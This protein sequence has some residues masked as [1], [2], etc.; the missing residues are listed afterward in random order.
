MQ[1]SISNMPHESTAAPT[2]LATRPLA[3]CLLAIWLSVS[4]CDAIFGSKSDETTDEIF[5]EGQIDPTL[6]DNVG[7]VPLNPFYTLSMLGGFDAPIDVYVGYDE[8]IYVADRQGLHVLDLAGRPQNFISEIG[9]P[10]QP[11]QPLRDITAIVQDRR[12]NLYVAARRDTTV[13]GAH[14]TS[15]PGETERC[16]LAVIYRLSGLTSGAPRLENIIWHP[17]DDGSRSQSRFDLPD[18]YQAESGPQ[19]SDDDASFTG[20]AVLADNTLYAVRSG[21]VNVVGVDGRP[22]STFSPFNAL[23]VYD[24][25]GEYVRFART[26]SPSN[27][28]LLSAVWPTAVATYVG[29]PQRTSVDLTEDFVIAQG[30]PGS[31]LRYAVLSILNVS[32]PDGDVFQVDTGR[33]GAS[34]NPEN[35]D[36]FLYGDFRFERPMGLAIAADETGYLFVVDTAKDSLLVFNRVGVEG[37]APPPGAG[38]LRPVKVS[39]GG[40]G[41]GPLQFRDPSGVAYFERI[42]YVADT[43]NNRIARYRL[44]TDFE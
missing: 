15:Y 6:V 35:G 11:T 34:S 2:L 25:D 16:D 14:C 17:F 44:N 13:A 3:I 24:G 40:E 31:A 33:L 7:Y 19:Y 21:P 8:L 29:P 26:L 38:N 9:W 42:V 32:T 4:G 36:G 20:V 28:S 12:F 39:F 5:D 41:S 22:N 43:G 30:P 37:V 10:G 23:M 27:P 18:V 1:D